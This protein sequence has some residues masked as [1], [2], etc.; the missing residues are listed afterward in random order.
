M[1]IARVSAWVVA[2]LFGQRVQY[3]SMAKHRF[4]GWRSNLPVSPSFL[5]GACDKRNSN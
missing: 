5:S 3:R 1:C 2:M 4:Q